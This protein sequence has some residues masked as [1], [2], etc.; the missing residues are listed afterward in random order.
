MSRFKEGKIYQRSTDHTV[1]I[2]LQGAKE[3]HELVNSHKRILFV[4]DSGDAIQFI[5]D[6]N[7]VADSSCTVGYDPGNTGYGVD[8]FVTLMTRK[9]VRRLNEE[10]MAKET[11]S[12]YK[13][14]SNLEFEWPAKDY[15]FIHSYIF[16]EDKPCEKN[17]IEFSGSLKDYPN[18]PGTY[19]KKLDQAVSGEDYNT[20]ITVITIKEDCSAIY[21]W[22]KEQQRGD[23]LPCLSSEDKN[24]TLVSG[25]HS[26]K[27]NVKVSI[28]SG[29]S[30]LFEIESPPT[31]KLSFKWNSGFSRGIDISTYTKT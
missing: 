21:S 11:L 6:K 31:L 1:T 3:T 9:S 20:E 13:S 28:S 2:T 10:Q 24:G 23:S 16:G 7:W 5:E 19:T 14:E 27:C 29:N 17:E 26:T 30:P 22:K 15:Q 18:I 8:E 4:P 25:T 12:E